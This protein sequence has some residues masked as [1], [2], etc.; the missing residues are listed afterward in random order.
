LNNQA[1]QD[2]ADLDIQAALAV[3]SESSY[4]LHAG[5]GAG[6]TR[7][8]VAAVEWIIE[9]R[10]ESLLVDGARVAVVT[11]T[12]AA[13]GEI[14]KRLRFNPLV[15]VSTIH[16]FAW[17]MIRDFVPDLSEWLRIKITDELENLEKKEAGGR[18]KTKASDDRLRKIARQTQ[19][20]NELPSIK[21][22]VYAPNQTRVDRDGLSH[23]EVLSAFS[24]FVLEKDTFRKILAGRYPIFMID[25]A[26]DTNKDVLAALLFVEEESPKSFVLGLFGDTMQRVY[27][28]GLPNLELVLPER[29]SKPSKLVNH[30]SATRIV[31]LGNAI[32]QASPEFAQIPRADAAKGTVQLFL[33]LDTS[34]RDTVESIAR[35]TMGMATEDPKWVELGG[36]NVKT[37][38]LEHA[39]AAKRLGFEAFL[40]PFGVD[41]DLKS[42]MMSRESSNSPQ[43]HFLGEQLVALAIALL[44]GDN[45]RADLIL[46]TYSPY[47][48]PSIKPSI[49][50]P[51]P[52]QI[53]VARSAVADLGEALKSESFRT[54]RQLVQNVANSGLLVVPEVL[55]DAIHLT[56]N[57]SGESPED[58]VDLETT[59]W[60]N[61]MEADFDQFSRFYEY[62]SG[63]TQYDTQQ[64]VKG[65]EFPRVMVIL[66]D[67]EANGFLFKY[68]KL[69]GTE[70]LS[71]TDS[72]NIAAGID[73]VLD[74]S[75]RLLYVACTRAIEGL[76][77]VLYTN[78]LA[79][80]KVHAISSGW[81]K[82]TEIHEISS[83]GIAAV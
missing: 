17:K 31:E 4:F 69:F 2:Q 63:R 51:S 64:G 11:Y 24:Y 30:R 81:F 7:S 59:V 32:R 33:A 38:I 65:L 19:R 10:G 42:T 20:L 83:A 25:E 70:P 77:V 21:K 82:E 78:D 79:A 48:N 47:L 14:S 5:A 44:A 3:G 61:A 12:N 29:W 9:S 76:V 1:D 35:N 72:E 45:Y 75:R 66:D 68:G 37:L 40:L 73:S 55:Q 8:L 74:R 56:V 15:D 54:L 57:G 67:L 13:S 60:A 16:S 23:Q 62:V 41:P 71:K 28:D 34:D 26:Q 80:A 27:M 49:G 22:F 58:E 39:M 18:K 50:S 6:K 36:V 52:S 46:K 43:V 53:D